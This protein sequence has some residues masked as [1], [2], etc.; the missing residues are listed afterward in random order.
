MA[1]LPASQEGSFLVRGRGG[2]HALGGIIRSA[3]SGSGSSAQV[4]RVGPLQD[5]VDAL[6]GRERMIAALSAAFGALAALLASIGLYGVMAYGVAGRTPELGIRIAVG[7]QPSDVVR[8]ILKETMQLVAAGGCA[9]LAAVVDLRGTRDANGRDLVA[10]E[11]CVADEVASAAELV[12]GKASS[13]PVAVV[14]GVDPAWLRRGSVSDEILRP[15]SE[16]LFR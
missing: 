10:T 11:V 5:I 7:A 12:M 16:D 6:A 15:P 2:A 13:V 8:L 14:R 9:G 1:Y 4:E 3:V